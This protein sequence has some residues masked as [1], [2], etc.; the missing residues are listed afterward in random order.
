[1]QN[2]ARP[3]AALARVRNQL[4]NLFERKVAEISA[5]G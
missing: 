5:R 3:I 4:L 2:L 1:M